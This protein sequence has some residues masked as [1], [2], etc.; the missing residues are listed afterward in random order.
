MTYLKSPDGSVRRTGRP[1]LVWI[2]CSTCMLGVLLVVPSLYLAINGALHMKAEADAFYQSFGVLNYVGVLVSLV[3]CSCLAVSL[4]R[5]KAHAVYF[6][7]ALAGVNLAKTF[8]Y[9][10]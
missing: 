7:I 10:P 8:V 6:A 2:I 5:L 3:L 4:F 1:V 9:F